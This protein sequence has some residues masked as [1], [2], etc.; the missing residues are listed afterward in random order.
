MAGKFADFEQYG[1]TSMAVNLPEVGTGPVAQQ[2]IMHLH[3]E[4]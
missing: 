1:S 2:R 4:H 3:K